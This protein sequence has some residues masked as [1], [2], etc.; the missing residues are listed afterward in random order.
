MTDHPDTRRS[1]CPLSV[2]MSADT[3]SIC[4]P[5]PSADLSRA[6]VAFRPTRVLAD[7]RRYFPETRPNYPPLVRS[8]YWA[9]LDLG[10]GC[11]GCAP[12]PDD[13]LR[14]SNTTGIL[15]KNVVYWCKLRHSLVVHPLLRKI[16]DPP[17]L[18]SIFSLQILIKIIFFIQIAL[19]YVQRLSTVQSWPILGRQTT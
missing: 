7:R 19:V 11:R 6:S 14:L 18:S 17:L 13:D 2:D 9:G 10:G 4:Q 15:K 8:R 5:K 12:L 3:R 1:T 16:L